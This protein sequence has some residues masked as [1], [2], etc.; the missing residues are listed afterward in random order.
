MLPGGHACEKTVK[1]NCSLRVDRRFGRSCYAARECFGAWNVFGTHVGWIVPE[2]CWKR[3]G[4]QV[5]GPV[6]ACNRLAKLY[7]DFQPGTESDVYRPVRVVSDS[8]ACTSK[9]ADSFTCGGQIPDVQWD[10]YRPGGTADPCAGSR[11]YGNRIDDPSLTAG[12]CDILRLRFCDPAFRSFGRKI[13]EAN[14]NSLKTALKRFRLR[15]KAV[16]RWV[17][18]LSQVDLLELV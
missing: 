2:R 11:K 4:T 16:L 14:Q 17:M 8:S 18:W 12:K 10:C 6:V 7:I 15:F 13:L 3:V 9:V 5:S 1:T